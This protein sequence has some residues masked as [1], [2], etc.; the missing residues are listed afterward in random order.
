MKK[1]I[2]IDN[3]SGD[4]AKSNMSGALRSLKYNGGC[5]IDRSK[6]TLIH[7]FHKVEK[8]LEDKML[9]TDNVI[10][11]WSMFTENHHSSYDQLCDMMVRAGLMEVKGKVFIDTATY[12]KDALTRAIE[13]YPQAVYIAR[14]IENNFIIH[15]DEDEQKYYRLRFNVHNDDFLSNEGVDLTKLI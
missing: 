14:C 2:F 15:Y 11:T 6:V 9:D 12:L 3:D 10:I 8:E 1:I 7:E 4:K 5:D 13:H